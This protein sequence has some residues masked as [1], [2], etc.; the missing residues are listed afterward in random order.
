MAFTKFLIHF[1]FIL[2]FASAV[3]A[4]PIDNPI[5]IQAQKDTDS[6]INRKGKLVHQVDGKDAFFN[7][8][9]CEISSRFAAPKGEYLNDT[10][11]TISTV[12]FTFTSINPLRGHGV[13]Q[14][15]SSEGQKTVYANTFDQLSGTSINDGVTCG[16]F[17][18][19][20]KKILKKVNTLTLTP[21]SV[22]FFITY[23]CESGWFSETA[24]SFL[25]R[26]EL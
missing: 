9:T 25:W 19:F 1:S 4:S 3:G 6:L 18:H 2:F 10:E 11:I 26:C 23:A 13:A 21:H 22:E 14:R 12:D 17:W 5:N 15:I 20:S 24:H 16:S 7:Q 8:S